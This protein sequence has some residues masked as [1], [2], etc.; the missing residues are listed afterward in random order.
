M[1]LFCKYPLG[2][3]QLEFSQ[4]RIII[5]N[6]NVNNIS[7]DKAINELY[8]IHLAYPKNYRIIA[9]LLAINLALNKIIDKSIEA[10]LVKKLTLLLSNNIKNIEASSII[11][12]ISILKKYGISFEINDTNTTHSKHE[13]YGKK[14]IYTPV[15]SGFFS[16]IENIINAKVIAELNNFEIIVNLNKN[17][18]P[19]KIPFE[20]IFKESF[21]FTETIDEIN[22]SSFIYFRNSFKNLSI[23]SWNQYEKCK[24]NNY[25]N[26]FNTLKNF[27][28][29]NKIHVND[30]LN[31]TNFLH[32]YIRRGDKLI[33]EDIN[34]STEILKNNLAYVSSGYER[35]KIYSDDMVWVKNNLSNINSNVYFDNALGNG[36]IFGNENFDDDK[37]I[38]RKYLDL[39]VTDN[40]TGDVG[41]NLVNAIAYTRLANNKKELITC[42]LFPASKIPLI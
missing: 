38:I 19:Y 32:L 1:I 42:N 4:L 20:T 6:L 40:F 14:I 36:Y 28:Y 9:C 11:E 10:E 2:E 12:I 30:S 23:N 29:S 15:K 16:I 8:K 24:I 13:Y 7:I 34:Y 33:L 22:N 39:S 31:T 17:W 35:I 26:I 3:S 25:K 27:A 18:W 41:S 5:E 37:E 21:Q